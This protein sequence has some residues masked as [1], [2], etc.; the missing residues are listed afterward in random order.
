M[1]KNQCLFVYYESIKRGLHG[2]GTGTPKDKD[3]VKR[4]EVCDEKFGSVKGECET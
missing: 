4:R 2:R 1:V 3:E